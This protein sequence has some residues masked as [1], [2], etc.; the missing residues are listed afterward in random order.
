MQ[1]IPLDPTAQVD[2]LKPDS[3]DAIISAD[4]AMKI[5]DPTDYSIT[6]TFQY[7]WDLLQVQLFSIQNTPVTFLKLIIFVML[8][9]G[10]SLFASFIK[11]LLHK[12]VLPRFVRDSGLQY[13][14]A[15]ISQYIV[16]VIGIFFAFQFLGI[17][18]T[19][20]AVIFGFLSV[21]IGFGLQNIT[22]N[23]ISGL[24]VLF[25]RPISVGDRVSVND[26][27]GDIQEINIR[28]TKVKTLDNIS[29]IVPNSE[30]VSKDVINFS[31]GDSTYRLSI[32]VGVSYS[33]NLDTVLKALNEVAEE[34]DSVL[35]TIEHEVQLR[36]FGDSSWDMK[37]LVWIADVKNR[38]RVQN[39]LN[40]AIVR[41]F[42]EYDIE[43]PF[44]QR[45]L[46]VRSGLTPV[47][48]GEEKKEDK[49]SSKKEEKAKDEKSSQKKKSE[50]KEEVSESN[51]AKV[52]KKD[53]GED[54]KSSQT[55]PDK[56]D[57]D[58]KK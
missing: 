24:I 1:Q 2:S 15:R 12:R 10:F 37:L 21:G 31:H 14:L 23:F 11:R 38:Y 41:K 48:S 44:P 52:E 30:F 47:A 29:I 13:T 17:D 45:D 34:S 20:L 16:T 51:E 36:S 50:S 28:S 19:G 57:E 32:D 33:S 53:D 18:M 54:E 40:Q 35:R 27:E 42:A 49:Q 25:E 58:S 8:L 26:I 4:S 5:P 6:E 3:A 55:R 22:S 43:I 56:D 46:H 39:E 7:I 9:I